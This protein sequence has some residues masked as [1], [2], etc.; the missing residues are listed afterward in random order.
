MNFQVTNFERHWISL[1][2]ANIHSIIKLSVEKVCSCLRDI[3]LTMVKGNIVYL[4]QLKDLLK[5]G[6]LIQFR[7]C[8]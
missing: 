6:S 7:D 1:E 3:K 2:K 8:V 5:S 4:R